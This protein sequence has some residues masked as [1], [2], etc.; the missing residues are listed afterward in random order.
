MEG[1]A[2]HLE[3]RGR[4]MLVSHWKQNAAPTVGPDRRCGGVRG[5]RGA[6]VVRGCGASNRDFRSG[7]IA[8]A[9]PRHSVIKR[10]KEWSRDSMLKTTGVDPSYPTS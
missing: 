3:G 6:R 9:T 8:N 7:R 4:V 10:I 5:L 1:N 2:G